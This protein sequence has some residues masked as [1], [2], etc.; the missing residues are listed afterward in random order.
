MLCCAVL[1]FDL[2]DSNSMHTVLIHLYLRGVWGQ[3]NPT[4]IVPGS[5]AI[6]IVIVIEIDWNESNQ[7]QQSATG[8]Q[9]VSSTA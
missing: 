5:S 8:I 4:T 9:I 2:I 6:L 3:C 1:C 7:D